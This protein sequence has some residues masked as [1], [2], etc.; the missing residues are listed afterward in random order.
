MRTIFA[1]NNYFWIFIPFPKRNIKINLIHSSLPS[2]FYNQSAGNAETLIRDKF[3]I[4]FPWGWALPTT[5]LS[6]FSLSQKWGPFTSWMSPLISSVPEVLCLEYVQKLC[7]T[8]AVFFLKQIFLICCLLD[9]LLLRGG[10]R[11]SSLFFLSQACFWEFCFVQSLSPSSACSGSRTPK[12]AT[13]RPS[14]ARIV[15]QRL[16]S[17]GQRKR[18]KW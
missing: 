4:C 7:W 17:L 11:S 16:S 5:V 15:C 6:V 18:R 10:A 12:M 2:P 14:S 1:I 3:E 9:V 8:P 13:G